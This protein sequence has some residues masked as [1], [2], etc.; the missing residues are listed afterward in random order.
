MH[1]RGAGCPQCSYELTSEKLRF[2]TEEFVQKSIAIHGSHYDYSETQYLLSNQPVKIICRIHG[3]FEQLASVHL[4]GAGCIQC[5]RERL[6]EKLRSNTEDFINKSKAIHGNRYN[7]SFV[8]YQSAVKKVKIICPKH[9]IF[10]QNPSG[11]LTGNGC[12]KCGDKVRGDKSRKSVESFISESLSAHGARYD[13]SLV[14]YHTAHKKVKIICP[15]HGV[16]EQSPNIHIK[17]RGCP[18]CNYG[19]GV[20]TYDED[21]FKR[22]PDQIDESSTIY[23]IRF[24]KNGQCLYKIGIDSNGKRWP[25]TYRGWEV[26]VLKQFVDSKYNCWIYES[27]IL[28]QNKSHRYKVKHP[29]FVGNG[30]TEMFHFDILTEE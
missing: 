4:R 18:K 30:A 13:Y 16:F 8:D 1:L 20:G 10:E 17:G 11:H 28:E 22:N 15:E 7:Y 9:G 29:D 12:E 23:Y 2:N 3:S 26:T 6:T 14:D 24:S 5:A 25:K 21:F 27:N 19:H